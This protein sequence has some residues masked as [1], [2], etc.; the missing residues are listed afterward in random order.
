MPNNIECIICG[1]VLSQEE[2]DKQECSYCKNHPHDNTPIHFWKPKKPKVDV[3]ELDELMGREASSHPS[4][5]PSA[6]SMKREIKSLLNKLLFLLSIVAIAWVAS[7]LGLTEDKVVSFGDNVADFYESL[8]QSES[9]TANPPLRVPQSIS[10]EGDYLQLFNEYREGNGLA[11]LTIDS[12]LNEIAMQRCFE[13]SSPGQFSHEGI[14]KYKLGENIAKLA[15]STDTNYELSEL[16]V[17]SAGHRENMLT[18]RYT[19]TGFARIG[20]Y[21]VQLFTAR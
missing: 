10:G 1:R 17:N 4:V 13:I 14:M 8:W 16:W 12:N 3:S 20:K 6:V 19:K 7:S 18:A 2:L 5:L 21:A 9:N 11:P 15:Y